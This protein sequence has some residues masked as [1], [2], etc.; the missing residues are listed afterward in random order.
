MTHYTK[1]TML[2]G[3]AVAGLS[4]V[5]AHAQEMTEDRPFSGVYIGA[6]GGYDIQNN[7]DPVR[8]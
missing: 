2:T 4:A 6:A 5:P 3:L 7:V 8:P 1:L